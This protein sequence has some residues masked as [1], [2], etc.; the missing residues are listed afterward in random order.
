MTDNI[1]T[2]SKQMTDED[3]FMLNAKIALRKV[4]IKETA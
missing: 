3:A 4:T 2:F 1:Q